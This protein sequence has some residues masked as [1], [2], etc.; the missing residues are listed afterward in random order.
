MLED[1][2]IT[3]V[4]RDLSLQLLFFPF[5]NQTFLSMDISSYGY[6][7]PGHIF[8]K[9]SINSVEIHLLYANIRDISAGNTKKKNKTKQ[10]QNKTKQNKNKNKKKLR[11]VLRW[12]TLTLSTRGSLAARL[13]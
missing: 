12:A 8:L 3:A 7:Y 2:K 6:K 10:K 13:A 5:K 4:I 9:V 11:T 1:M